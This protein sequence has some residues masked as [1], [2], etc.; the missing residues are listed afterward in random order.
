MK[1][2]LRPFRLAPLGG[3]LL[4]S[5]AYATPQL[6][7]PPGESPHAPPDIA[8][9]GLSVLVTCAPFLASF[10]L[11]AWL[12][13]SRRTEGDA[14][15]SFAARWARSWLAIGLVTAGVLSSALI[16][17]IALLLMV[18]GAWVRCR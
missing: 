10:G 13:K 5:V 2:L 7:C 12:L 15:G 1:K 6:H 14:N 16:A 4:S 8:I 11:A 3:V 17:L 9:V 18:S